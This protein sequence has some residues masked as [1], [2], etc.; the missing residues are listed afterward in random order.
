MPGSEMSDPGGAREE[1]GTAPAR[2]AEDTPVCCPPIPRARLGSQAG[3]HS[4]SAS[5]H[6]ERSATRPI[7]RPRHAISHWRR[8]RARAGFCFACR[9]GLLGRPRNR[10]RTS[11][12]VIR[13]TTRTPAPQP[14][15]SVA[16][17]RSRPSVRI[18]CIGRQHSSNREACRAGNSHKLAI[19][20][21]DQ[22]SPE[23]Q[24]K[25]AN[26]HAERRIATP[27]NEVVI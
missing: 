5:G 21:R 22:A 20:V 19:G 2:I 7:Y 6:T 24:R 27:S 23:R 26:A 16:S 14:F 25:G 12:A 15:A 4:P 1:P 17:V 18:L 3:S 10:R 11:A 13:C 9:T 8:H